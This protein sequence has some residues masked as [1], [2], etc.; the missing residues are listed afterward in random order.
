MIRT[1][2]VELNEFD[3]VAFRQKLSGKRTGLVIMKFGYEQPGLAFIDNN[4]RLPILSKNTPKVFTMK[5]F[6]EAKELTYGLT[7]AKHGKFQLMGSKL[8]AKEIGE[9]LEHEP[10][11]V[12]ELVCSD[13][14]NKIIETFKDKKGDFSHLLINRDFLKFAKSSQIVQNMLKN[15]ASEDEIRDFVVKSR[16]ETITSNHSISDSQINLIVDLLDEVHKQGVFKKL[17]SEIRK[18]KRG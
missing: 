4:R 11:E 13:T 7:F 5:A 16:F 10:E 6:A 9:D 15:N 17:N 1:K 8:N 18:M 2:V 12:T 14:Y 3:G